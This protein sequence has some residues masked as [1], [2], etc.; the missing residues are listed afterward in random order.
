MNSN[1]V[2]RQVVSALA[3]ALMGAIVLVAEL[4]AQDVASGWGAAIGACEPGRPGFTPA[5][6]DFRTLSVVEAAVVARRSSYA[7]PSLGRFRAH[8]QGHVFFYADL[9]DES[10]RRLIRSDQVA[11]ELD[12]LG[13]GRALQTVVGRRHTTSFPTGIRYHMDHLA[14]AVDNFGDR[15]SIGEGDEVTEVPHPITVHGLS[16]YEY[17]LVD[18]LGI[19]VKDEVTHV[20]RVQVRPRCPED[21]GVVGTVDVD[22]DSKAIARLSLTFTPSTYVDPDVEY[23]TVLLE[24]QWMNQRM[25]LPYEQRI[26]IRRRTKYFDLP[27]GGTIVSNLRVLEYDFSPS[28]ERQ[29]QPGDHVVT[30]PK[31]YL[32]RFAGWESG[33]IAGM[34]RDMR[35]DSIRLAGVRHQ[36]LAV[37]ARRYLGGNARVRPFLSTVSDGLRYS[38]AEGLVVGLGMRAELSGAQNVTARAG[39][40]FERREPDAELRIA[41]DDVRLR[42]SVGAYYNRQK[43]IGPFRA[44]SG[45]VSSIGAAVRGDDFLDPYFA[46]G[47]ELIVDLPLWGG[48]TQLGL[49]FE[50]HSEAMLLGGPIGEVAARPV[51]SILAGKEF[52]VTM[53]TEQFLGGGL[54]SVWTARARSRLVPLGDFG[55]SSWVF[56]L[57]AAPGGPET[58]WAFEMDAELALATGELPPQQTL[59][60][61]GRGTVPGW[62]FRGWGG[63]KALYLRG[64]VSQKAW[65]PWAR[66]RLLGATGWSDLS[67]VSQQAGTLVGVSDSNGFRSS[68]GGGIALF[69]DL[70]RIDGMRGLGEFGEWEWMISLNKAFWEVL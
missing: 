12:W 62:P 9:G 13:R 10:A 30:L 3:L 69:Y 54:G 25:W 23:V 11:V 1:L 66:L 15:I 24:N 63:D 70:L 58:A 17:R 37:A 49:N 29:V 20:Y 50:E 60:I 14:L 22:R 8:A 21:S 34:P 32:E 28:T 27:L 5:W 26:E 33:A 47:V 55:Y 43:D 38:R 68:L 65:F 35:E 7:E 18:S 40:Q 45:L 46:D 31:R 64:A 41:F 39:Y 52:A 48:R 42:G 2:V 44:S 67:S 4:A 53:R 57:H 51:R 6:N 56:G 19:K 16:F 59:L 36:A 61:G